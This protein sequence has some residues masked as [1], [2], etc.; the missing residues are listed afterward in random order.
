[1]TA[2]P[3]P[4][5]HLGAMNY[6]AMHWFSSERDLFDLD[7]PYQRGSVW[8]DEMRVNL[9]KSLLMGIPT[10]SIVVAKAR[11]GTMYPYRIVDGKQRIEAIRAFVDNE[12]GVPAHWWHDDD[13][14]GFRRDAESL[15]V[16]V[17]YEE[18][19][20]Q[21]KMRV[22]MFTMPALECDLTQEFLG[23]GT[24]GKERNWRYRDDDETL[25]AEATLYGLINFG[26]VEQTDT[27]R[28]RAEAIA[29]GAS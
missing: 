21:G 22:N 15:G 24:S 19:T 6:T 20:R 27:D 1:M 7:A 10:G 29:G 25:R 2:E 9:I 4:E 26:G 17:K 14:V 8:T 28:Q 18:L 23:F 12:F 5:M 11:A 3:L 16:T 13:M